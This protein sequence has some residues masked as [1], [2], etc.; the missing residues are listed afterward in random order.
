MEN[1][2]EIL[3]KLK[4]MYEES[5][6]P[7]EF[8]GLVSEMVSSLEIL[9][10]EY[11]KRANSKED[12]LKSFVKFLEEDE[13]SLDYNEEK[14]KVLKNFSLSESDFDKVIELNSGISYMA[15]VSVVAAALFASE[16][17]Y[18]RCLLM[19]H[20]IE[21][22]HMNDTMGVMKKMMFINGVV[23]RCRKCGISEKEINEMYD[24]CL[25]SNK[26]FDEYETFKK[27]F[28]TSDSKKDEGKDDLVVSGADKSD[29]LA[30]EPKEN[31]TPADAKFILPSLND[32]RLSDNLDSIFKVLD[33]GELVKTSESLEN[34]VP[35]N[36][37]TSAS[38][39][40]AKS[41][42]SEKVE[43][44][45]FSVP[46]VQVSSDFEE[47]VN[48]AFDSALTE[49]LTDR[50]DIAA[51]ANGIDT[52]RVDTPDSSEKHDVDRNKNDSSD[53]HS[54]ESE[55]NNPFVRTKDS[56]VWTGSVWGDSDDLKLVSP[57]KKPAPKK[58]EKKVKRKT[59]NEEHVSLR[60]KIVDKC[61]KL[62]GLQ[63]DY[64]MSGGKSK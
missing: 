11:A 22:K 28:L 8:N 49:L 44:P 10:E 63:D 33:S 29:A 27:D 19:Y 4:K 24:S 7:S 48:S 16:S 3:E 2:S 51:R 17:D 59:S 35:K 45:Q 61:I 26:F 18:Y 30:S 54:T 31:P 53:S 41:G 58:I 64:K 43:M 14:E 60:K 52:D 40:F 50:P 47:S 21:C 39:D 12:M 13:L 37:T 9:K 5:V 42:G 1:I 56:I 25:F 20:L 55:F 38:L 23:D 15:K 6:D 46:D 34:D 32:N 57:R 36:S 62:L